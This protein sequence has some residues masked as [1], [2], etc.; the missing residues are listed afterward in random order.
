MN[1]LLDFDHPP[2]SLLEPEQRRAFDRACDIVLFEQGQR[3]LQQGQS[4]PAGYFIIKGQARALR[5]DANGVEQALADYGPG[6]VMGAFA[7][8][9]GEARFT[10]EV[11]EDL[12]CHAVDAE[13]F[14]QALSANP[15]F[16]AWFQEGL[17]AK[18]SLWQKDRQEDALAEAM[19]V[20]VA[21]ARLAPVVRLEPNTSLRDARLAMKR[22][23]VS[24]VIVDPEDGG[25]PGIVTRTDILDALALEGASPETPLANWVRRP[26]LGV[27]PREVLFA[28]LVAMTEHHVERVVVRDGETILGTLG[29]GEV[30]SHF[31]SQSH[32]IGLELARAD[33]VEAVQAASQRVPELIRLLHAQGARISYLMEMV[34]AL[35]TRLLRRLYELILP[36]DWQPHCCVLV[37]GSEGRREQILRTD[38]DNA[39]IHPPELA[40]ADVEHISARFSEALIGC[41]FP[42]CPGGVMLRN[43]AWRGSPAHW[44]EHFGT[45][46]R[47]SE[48]T[49]LLE[50]AILLDA[51]PVAGNAAQFEALRP[52]LMGAADNDILLHHFAASALAFETPLTF[53]GR[54][55]ADGQRL[56]IK[57]G[58]IF[59]LVQGLRALALRH[60]IGHRNSFDRANALGEAGVL[61]AQLRRDLPQAMAV[62]QRLR[63]DQQLEAI[64]RGDVA[65]NLLRLDALRRLDRELLRD[66]LGVVESFKLLLRQQFHL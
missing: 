40:P 59:P 52:A 4:S 22:R 63:L 3:P 62:F 45:L 42:P 10:Y 58:G 66:A 9:Q 61:G 16:A 47:S 17:S 38:Q 18:R 29:I 57:K 56:D 11:T 24:C 23:D 30:L 54:L 13:V 19:L 5:I 26:L 55:R 46:A 27:S 25:G 39:L 12:L 8:M 14:Q 15:R 64:Q 49:R 33:T 7:V 60:R 31:S 6:D 37:L 51:R 28:S 2:L 44:R 36:A 48:P 53:F 21:D 20:R 50:F 34:S 43:A 35:N 41:G 32:L 65:D 1:P